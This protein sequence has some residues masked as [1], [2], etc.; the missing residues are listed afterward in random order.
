M[1]RRVCWAGAQNP[2]T[3][4]GNAFIARREYLRED[5]DKC[6]LC[7]FHFHFAGRTNNQLGKSGRGVEIITTRWHA[8]SLCSPPGW[9]QP[10]R[11]SAS[12][13]NTLQQR[14]ALHPPPASPAVIPSQLWD[15]NRDKKQNES[16]ALS[17]LLR[18]AHQH[19]IHLY[20]TDHSS[21]AASYCNCRNPTAIQSLANSS[22]NNSF[23]ASL[24]YILTSMI[25]NYW[26][27]D[28]HS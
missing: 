24:D 17:N 15:K 4:S 23:G 27:D 28:K 14:E 7:L 1:C 16:C 11:Q 5:K 26:E 3:D 21:L 22:Q 20:S 8:N 10:H 12:S 9:T 2:P 18:D 6:L 25:R 13:K 19:C